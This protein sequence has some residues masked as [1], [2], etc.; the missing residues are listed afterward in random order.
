[1][2]TPAGSSP[3]SLLWHLAGELWKSPP[4]CLAMPS[5][6]DFCHLFL[7]QNSAA[8]SCSSTRGHL[9]SAPKPQPEASRGSQKSLSEL[10]C[11]KRGSRLTWH[12]SG[13]GAAP[14]DQRPLYQ[15]GALLPPPASVD[16]TRE[17]NRLGRLINHSKCGNCQTKLHD[18]DGVPH[19]ILIASRDIA[20]G[21]ELLYD[22]GDRSRASLEAYP[23]LKH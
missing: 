9:D 20:A 3:T 4:S 12:Q 14:L 8:A 18:I 17:T 5:G 13:A 21:E 16:A 22:Y 23:W 10:N 7:L 6:A 15:F 19:L 2:Q 11:P 1:M